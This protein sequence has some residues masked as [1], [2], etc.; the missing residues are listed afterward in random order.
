MPNIK[1]IMVYDDMV[2]DEAWSGVDWRVN[3]SKAARDAYKH[4]VAS[5]G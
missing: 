5:A 2:Y 4:V 1:L 3:S